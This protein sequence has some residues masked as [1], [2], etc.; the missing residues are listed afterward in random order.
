MLEHIMGIGV[1]LL[2][3]PIVSILK[4]KDDGYYYWDENCVTLMIMQLITSIVLILIGIGML[5]KG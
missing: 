4:S 1:A 2:I 3:A 5:L